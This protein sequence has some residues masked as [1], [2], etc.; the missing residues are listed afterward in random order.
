LIRIC[1]LINDL[2]AGGAERALVNIVQRL[3]PLRFSNEVISLIEPGVFGHELRANGIPLTSLGMKRGRPNLFGLAKLVRHLH[4]SKPTI[5]QTWLYHA[6]LLGTVAL[7]F[8]PS[9]RLLWNVRCTDMATSP[10]STRLRW[11]S[12]LLARMS[13]LPDAVIANSERG[14]IFHQKI[15]YRPKRWIKIPNGV[16]TERF[17]PRF[18]MRGKRAELGIE[19]QGPV[20]G[21]VAR[22]H[23]M[24]DHKTFLQAAIKF[25]RDYPDA[26]F[27]LCGID[28]DVQNEDLNR[29]ISDTGLR[30]RVILL[31]IRD[32]METVYPA[33][34]LVT[35]CSTFGEG[36]PNTLIEAMACGVPCVATDIGASGEII[37]DVG[38]IVPPSDPAALA[39]AWSSIVTGPREALATKAR[40]RAVERYQITRVSQLYE[41]AYFDI[42]CPAMAAGD[43]CDTRGSVGVSN[44][45]TVPRRDA[46]NVAG[47]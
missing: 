12:K 31:G 4:Y 29:L 34:D 19:T 17:Q 27:V 43:A 30:D 3:D 28:C 9:A 41:T 33:F 10:G 8:A 38:L 23:P 21:M 18:D 45:I 22:Y 40:K 35:L 5:L 36:F 32:D 14:K 7:Q 1:H 25:S 37:E 20:V 16:D 42:A 44:A 46:D 11:I 13:G 6:D 26:R 47:S 39:Q 24:K 15:G 2:D